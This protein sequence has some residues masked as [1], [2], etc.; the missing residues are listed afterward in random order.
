M[1]TIRKIIFG[2]AL[3]AAGYY[4]G[5][6]SSDQGL[7]YSIKQHQGQEF[8]YDRA[9]REEIG[10]TR[11]NNRTFFSD[12][13]RNLEGFVKSSMLNDLQETYTKREHKEFFKEMNNTIEEM[14]KK[15][16]QN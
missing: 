9:N 13:K 15:N 16:Q 5:H 6:K 12:P 14:V 8:L 3:L 4:M 2:C 11:I 1:G 10:L 7:Q